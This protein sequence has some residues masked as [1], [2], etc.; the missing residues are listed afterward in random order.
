[1]GDVLRTSSSIG[2]DIVMRFGKFGDNAVVDYSSF[3]VEQNGERGAVGCEG[4]ERRGR[5]RFK[6]GC[7]C[8]SDEA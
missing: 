1:V 7:Y 6:E 3:V 2:Y 5:D 8:G 4:R